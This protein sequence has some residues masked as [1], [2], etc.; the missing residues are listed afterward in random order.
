[1]AFCA[2]AADGA[3][4][5]CVITVAFFQRRSRVLIGHPL[6]LGFREGHHSAGVIAQLTLMESRRGDIP[7]EISPQRRFTQHHGNAA[8]LVSVGD[9]SRHLHVDDMLDCGRQLRDNARAV[10]IVEIRTEI[11]IERRDS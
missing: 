4:I 7:A 6:R 1:M 3:D 2:A 9:H 5:A 8:H 10:R 11:V